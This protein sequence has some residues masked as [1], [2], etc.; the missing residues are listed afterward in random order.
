MQ[1][2][3]HAMAL[4]IDATHPQQP[5][6]E[7][8]GLV[9]YGPDAA[10]AVK[11]IVAAEADGVQQVWMTQ[12]T[13]TPDTMTLFAAAAVKTST[14]RLGTA[15]VPTYPRHPLALA[16]QALAL[17]DLAPG[18]LR[19]GVG[20]SHRPNIEGTYGLPMQPP[21]EHLR[22]YVTI[23]RSALWDGQ[24]EHQGRYYRV[25]A[26]LP[27]APR[28]PI[29]ISALREGAFQ[30]AGEIADGA[31]SWVCPVPFLLEKALP[32]L[33]AGAVRS[34]RPTPP[35]VAH[36]SVALNQDRQA[37]LAAAQQQIGRYARI[38]FYANMFADAGFPIGNDGVM[39]D[40]LIDN[41]VVSGD[42]AAI[43][44]HLRELL[45]QGLDELL[46]M[47]IFVSDA[48]RERS[49]LAKLLAHL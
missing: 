5:M 3:E 28:T 30:L 25:K 13:P 18:R 48:D 37:V 44:A 24:V 47:S 4:P 40:A 38:Q 42:E 15:I 21:L 45:T 2:E 49:Q 22:E 39:P 23:L 32:A 36:I 41:L 17:S 7:R 46:I 14:V 19:L 11:N 34:G 29:L 20:P 1:I 9:I 6:R 16:Q 12:G 31:I 26:K 35:L 10:A 8:V 33:R 43:T 27:R